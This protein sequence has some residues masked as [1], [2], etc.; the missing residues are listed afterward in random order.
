[1]AK[2]SF[3]HVDEHLASELDKWI[4]LYPQT[5]IIT[6]SN[7]NEA[8]IPRILGHLSE[9]D[10]LEILEIEPGEYS[11]SIE[12]VAHII[13]H[14]IDSQAG[15]DC[16]ILNIGGGVVTDLGGFV[17]SI[18][19]RGVQ[20]INIPTSLMAMCDASIGGKTG[21]DA[22]NVKNVIGTFAYPKAVMIQ[23]NFI[24]TLP[25]THI[26]SGFAEMLKHA[27]IS[28]PQLFEA[29]EAVE[30]DNADHLALFI[31]RSTRIKEEIVMEDFLEEGRRKILNFGHTVGHALES[32]YIQNGIPISHGHAVALGLVVESRISF[33]HGWLDQESYQR[34][35]KL[36]KKYF[37]FPGTPEWYEVEHFLAQ[38]KKNRNRE[39][40]FAIS[41]SMGTCD[42]DI[43]IALEEIRAALEEVISE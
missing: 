25:N 10:K 28:D 22:L 36:I 7:V 27:I 5:F 34:I 2:S 30:A 32:F 15:R 11:K 23:P 40:R 33:N 19:K 42:W 26:L 18:Y 21:I 29:L 16:L 35:A 17:A 4:N 1:M 31:E 3:H 8:V 43:P 6:D 24:S 41:K 13:D 39:V 37:E 14:L 12:V 20:F 38:D 9:P